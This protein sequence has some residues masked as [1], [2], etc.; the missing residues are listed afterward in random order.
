M[1]KL[2]RNS[3]DKQIKKLIFEELAD[4]PGLR[5]KELIELCISHFDFTASEFKDR[6]SGGVVV[7]TKSRIG[8]LLSAMLR[9]NDIT[10]NDIGQ[11]YVQTTI[12]KI[13]DY[14][15]AVEYL[16]SIL[17]PTKAMSKQRIYKMAEDE[18]RPLNDTSNSIRALMGSVLA[19]LEQENRVIRKNSGYILPPVSHLPNTELGYYLNK[20]KTSDDLFDCYINAVHIKGGEWFEIYAVE[21]ISIYYGRICGKTVTA[22][23]VCGGSNDGGIDGI[24]ETTDWLGFRENTLMQMKNRRAVMTSKDVREFYGAVCAEQGSRGVFV[25]ISS[26]HKDAETLIDKI[27]NLVGIDG[28]K[29]FEIASLCKFGII[30]ENGRLILDYKLFLNDSPLSSASGA[31]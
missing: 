19:R 11:M 18:F 24:V 4:N 14:D 22:A 7:Q 10:E 23:S 3:S 8:T 21:L 9:E 6:S 29:L 5:R 20:S 16:L 28:P 26:F 25:T 13:L 2:N 1:A 27:D 15:D 12:R 31:A 30:E 17:S